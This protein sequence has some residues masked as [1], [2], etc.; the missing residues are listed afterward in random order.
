MDSVVLAPRASWGCTVPP[1]STVKKP[2]V[3]HGAANLRDDKNKSAIIDEKYVLEG[4][5][6]MCS[7]CTYS[8]AAVVRTGAALM[9]AMSGL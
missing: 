4:Q 8:C 2:L 9:R 7:S 3:D 1:I 5:G 6:R